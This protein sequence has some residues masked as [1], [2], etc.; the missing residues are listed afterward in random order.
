M[1]E[2]YGWGDGSVVKAL[3]HKCESLSPIAGTHGEKMDRRILGLL[4][5]LSHKISEFQV[6]LETLSPKQDRE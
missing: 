5:S 4:T 3:Q 2:I 6:Q 1:I